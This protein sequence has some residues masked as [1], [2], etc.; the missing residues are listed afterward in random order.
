ML[1]KVPVQPP[2]SNAAKKNISYK[3]NYQILEAFTYS[4]F[5][6]KFSRDNFINKIRSCNRIRLYCNKRTI[7]I[8]FGFKKI[9][10]SILSCYFVNWINFYFN[11]IKALP[12]VSCLAVMIMRI[13]G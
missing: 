13:Q 9:E 3:S 8:S 1:V 12:V 5:V 2:A 10:S 7:S 11:I 6:A 4:V